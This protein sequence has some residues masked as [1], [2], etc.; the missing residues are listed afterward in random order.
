MLITI[1]NEILSLMPTARWNRPQQLFGYLEEE[2]RVA[3]EPLL[4]TTLYEHLLDE[5]DR[6]RGEYVD[7]TATTVRPSGKAKQDPRLAHADVTERLEQVQQGKYRET[8]T[9]AGDSE[10]DVPSD[11]MATI[12]LIRICQQIEFYKMLSHKAGL[13]T[14]SFNEGGGMNVVTATGYDETDDKRMERVVKDAYM[15]A[16]RAIDSLL[17]FLEADAK[18]D[19]L[20]TEKWQDAD[21]FY[22]HKDL[23]FQ[24]AR[25]LNEYL[26]IRGERMVYVQL[27]RD[28]RFC[29]DTYLKPM[30]GSKLLK[31]VVEY[32]NLGGKTGEHTEGDTLHSSLYDELLSLL[33]QALA[34]YVESRRTTITRTTPISGATTRSST[35]SSQ[36]EDKL[37]RRDSMTDAQQAMAMACEYIEENLDALGDAAVD[38]PIYKKVKEREAQA[39]RDNACACAAEARRRRAACEQ[40]SRKLFTAFPMTH[41]QPEH[42]T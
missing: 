39:A 21:A 38:S 17:L 2:E 37:A 26:D 19:Q 7:I 4:G 3:L 29:Q 28:I 15:S 8:Y 13:L 5:Y 25:V 10:Q 33:R 32:A 41:R 34:F 40:N 30:V 23:L 12:R 11:D 6:L 16:G 24:T 1:E 31:T 22:L 35:S 27:V 9:T 18:G 14:V 20:F 36:K 42:L